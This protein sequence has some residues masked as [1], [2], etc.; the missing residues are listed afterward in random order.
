[1]YD[2][3]LSPLESDAV[4]VAVF[5]RVHAKDKRYQAFPPPPLQITSVVVSISV[6]ALNPQDADLA[7]RP[8]YLTAVVGLSHQ[9]INLS[10]TV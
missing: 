2:Q 8:C 6:I 1:M 7:P 10:L 3:H 5:S 9:P 4:V